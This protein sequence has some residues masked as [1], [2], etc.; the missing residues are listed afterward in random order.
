M[1]RDV[2]KFLNRNKLQALTTGLKDP[3]VDL[4]SPLIGQAYLV[5]LD[6]GEEGRLCFVSSGLERNGLAALRLTQ[7]RATRDKSIKTLRPSS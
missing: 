5:S 1:P 4:V 3:H 7:S 2:I 6:P